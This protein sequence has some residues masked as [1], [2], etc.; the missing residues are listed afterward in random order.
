[1]QTENTQPKVE[2]RK[3]IQQGYNDIVMIDFDHSKNKLPYTISNIGSPLNW[4]QL[5]TIN[6]LGTAKYMVM[7]TN[8]LHKLAE[9]LEAIH[10]HLATN[11]AKEI[12][13]P[14]IMGEITKTLAAIS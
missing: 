9:A 3:L 5:G 8:N 12:D 7:A 2:W 11:T 1:M 6:D 4:M 14:W 10:A 13:K